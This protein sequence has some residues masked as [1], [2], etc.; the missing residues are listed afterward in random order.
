MKVIEVAVDLYRKQG[1]VKI[2]GGSKSKIQPMN[3]GPGSFLIY[4]F[5]KLIKN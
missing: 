5:G 1:S 4:N 2:L 3:P